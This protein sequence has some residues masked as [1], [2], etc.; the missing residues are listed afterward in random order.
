[1]D[2]LL[3]FLVILFV[4]VIALIIYANWPK[5]VGDGCNTCEKPKPQCKCVCHK[6]HQPKPKCKC[7]CT[8]C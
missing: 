2:Y 3:P 4:G 6:C 1:M 8:F 7:P 5:S